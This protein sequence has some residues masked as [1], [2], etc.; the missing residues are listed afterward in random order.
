[1]SISSKNVEKLIDLMGDDMF[2]YEIGE[3]DLNKCKKEFQILLEVYKQ[4][5]DVQE[6]FE[7]LSKKFIFWCGNTDFLFEEIGNSDEDLTKFLNN[8]VE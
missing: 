7:E 6:T 2:S 4:N 8:L 1:M 3:E 5:R